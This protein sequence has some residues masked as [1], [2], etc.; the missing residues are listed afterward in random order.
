MEEYTQQRE[1]LE[2][3]LQ[4]SSFLRSDSEPGT[5]SHA[6]MDIAEACRNISE[7]HR[8]MLTPN[9]DIDDCLT[10]LIGELKHVIYHVNDAVE[11]RAQV[12]EGGELNR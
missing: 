10:K 5:L 1:L 11:L 3:R 4:K 9:S 7:I 12:F 8:G 2:L 6:V